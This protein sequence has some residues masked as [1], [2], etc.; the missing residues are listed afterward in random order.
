MIATE[1]FA[2]MPAS[3][4]IRILDHTYDFEKPL[5]KEIMGRLAK[6]RRMHLPV[7][8]RVPRSERHPWMIELLSKTAAIE[9][10]YQCVSG[11][12]LA[13]QAPMLIEFLDQT[14]IRH[15]GRGCADQFPAKPPPSAIIRHA[16]KTILDHHP[17]ES[18]I[19][20]LHAFN[21]MPDTRWPELD[22]ILKDDPNLQFPAGEA[23]L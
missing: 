10:A 11:W 6:A 19:V 15:D 22:A 12:L 21:G 1:L 8:Q 9:P 3:L 20:Y 16:V 14:G 23:V 2:R 17:R 18:V 5:Y 7:L 4:A 13:T